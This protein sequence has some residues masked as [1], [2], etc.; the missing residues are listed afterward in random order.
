MG[1]QRTEAVVVH[2]AGDLRF[3]E[4]ELPEQAEDEALVRIAYGGICGSDL[5]YWSEGTAGDSI[6]REP[7]ILGHEIV[8]VVERAAAD[9]SS[10]VEGSPVAVHP[11]TPGHGD[12]SR[13]PQGQPHLSPGARYLGSA[14]QLPHTQG[15]FC[16]QVVLPGRML[17]P[18]PPGLS[19]RDAAIAEPASVA[20]HAAAR[21]GEVT[22]KRVLVIGSGPIGALVVAVLARAEAAEIVA[23]DLHELPLQIARELGADRVL[24]ARDTEAIAAV[25]ADVTFECS[26]TS[27]GLASAVRATTR[28]GRIVMVGLQRSGNQPAP[29]ALAITRELDIVGSFRFNDEIDDVLGALADGSLSAAAV[30][31]REFAAEDVHEAFELAQDPSSSG[32]VLLRF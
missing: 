26:G 4:V 5:H 27:A 23:A 13:Y 25:D 11:G 16:R 28:G 29:L 14:A 32:K 9:G 17:R 24:D 12:G 6:L 15:A 19:L 3:E 2:G 21:G 10:P 20:W 1:N 22:G 18:L 8:G 30:V 31:T 7:M